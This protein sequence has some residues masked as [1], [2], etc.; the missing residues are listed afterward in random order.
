MQVGLSLAAEGDALGC[1]EEHVMTVF[2]WKSSVFVMLQA[3]MMV[4]FSE[5]TEDER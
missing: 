1:A 2:S 4:N 5:R 3:V